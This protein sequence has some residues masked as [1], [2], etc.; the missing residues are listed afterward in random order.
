MIIDTQNNNS[1]I[2][3]EISEQHLQS[4]LTENFNIIFP[5]LRFLDSEFVLQGDVQQF[6]V[7]GRIDILALNIKNQRLVIF[8]LKTTHS[9]N[10]LLQALDYSDFIDQHL[11]SI[12]PRFVNLSKEEI[13]L[14]L[15]KRN[16][17]EIILIAKNFTHPTIRRA[18]KITNYIR[19]YN[20]RYYQNGLVQLTSI[21]DSREENRK[22]QI[23]F[24]NKSSNTSPE[25][26]VSLIKELLKLGL[27]NSDYY[28]IESGLLKFNP[29]KLYKS[30]KDY[31]LDRNEIPLSKT[32]FFNNIKS[33][34]SFQGNINSIRFGENRTSAMK[35]KI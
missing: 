23:D 13:N 21:V 14:L 7:S 28:K 24:N 25:E 29:T 20:Y 19:L 6:G 32:D 15:R 33:S 9:K 22:I 34:V 12:L 3:L 31:V 1:F 10:I 18:E 5:E 2:E 8:E 4:I 11:E 26:T 16:E 35:L 27:V 30:Y 17:P